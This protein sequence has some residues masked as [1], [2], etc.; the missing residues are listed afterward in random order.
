[1][2]SSPPVPATPPGSV[3]FQRLRVLFALVVREMGARF[4]RSAGGF[5][6]M[7]LEPLGGIALLAIAF[8]LALRSPPLG[9]S[10]ILFYS[11][12]IIP[13]FLFN[14]MS[15]NVSGAVNSN[16]GLLSYPVVTALDTILAKA[17]LSFA[18]LFVVAL[19]LYCTIIFGL[20][21]HVNLDLGAVALGFALAAVLGLGVGTLNC[22]LFGFFPTWKNVWG[23]LTRPLFI[24]SAIF[25]TFESVPA[26]FQAV[27]WWNPLVHVIGT[28]R[29]GFYGSYDPHY[30]SF[31]YLLGISGFT[32]AVGA[33][34][35]R[36]HSAFLIE[37]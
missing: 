2:S 5:A 16:R 14:T 13:F 9:T 18:T 20:G 6:W 19:L 7:I 11:T 24:V 15:K 10:F 4:G 1:M 21:V 22:V 27:L 33:Y 3:R 23:V 36:R 8:S 17:A 30:V 31:A 25:F 34:L 28:M 37:Q 35:L 12:G 26:N 29:S 32:F